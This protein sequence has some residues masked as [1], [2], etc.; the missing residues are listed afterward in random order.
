M[1]PANASSSGYLVKV[2]FSKHPASDSNPAAV[3]ALSRSSPTLGVATFAAHQLIVGPTASERTADYFSALTGA[4]S[5]VSSCGGADF[6][7]VLNQ[8]GTR[9]ESGTA[10][11]QFCRTVAIAGELAG[12]RMA[13]EI[14]NTLRQ[15]TNITNVVILTK[16]GTCFNDLSG[17]NR[18]LSAYVVKV[19]FSRHPASD[20][21]PSAVSSVGRLSPTLGVA[22]FSLQ[23]LL[24]GPLPAERDR[25]LYT[26]LSGALS[27]ASNCSGASFSIVLNHKGSVFEQGTATVRFCRAVALAGD[28]TGARIRS[29]ITTTLRQF[30]TITK[31]VILRRDGTCFDD[32]SGQNLCL[33]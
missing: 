7:I 30:S 22:T 18:C 2:Y 1:P 21:D 12:A 9:P 4:L 23:Q 11:L 33:K 19:F 13:A 10:T 15:F 27:G 5:G 20:N 28:L 25:S 6:R 26:P 24:S 8:R 17:L 14:E 16:G 31:V 3:F 29:E 32:L